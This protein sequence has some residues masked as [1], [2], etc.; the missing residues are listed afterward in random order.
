M[1]TCTNENFS[2]C[3]LKA[4]Q[5]KLLEMLNCIP[6][7][8]PIGQD[9]T[10][11][12]ICSKPVEIADEEEYKRA[13]QYLEKLVFEI[14]FQSD[15]KIENDACMQSCSQL[16]FDIKRIGTDNTDFASNWININF[17]QKVTTIT[18]KVQNFSNW[19]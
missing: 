18:T 6:P 1:G 16:I 4:I 10:E 9:L 3:S 19:I 12:I 5:T 14:K 7:W 8:L 11:T 2:D 15:V 13:V 17:A